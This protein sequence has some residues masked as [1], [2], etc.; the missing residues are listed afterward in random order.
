MSGSQKISVPELPTV[1]SMDMSD[2]FLIVREGNTFLVPKSGLFSNLQPDARSST[3]TTVKQGTFYF[4]NS[5][6]YFAV[7]PNHL[8]MVNLQDF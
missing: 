6:L 3:A 1:N 7:S 2:Q 4:S 8:K 5:A